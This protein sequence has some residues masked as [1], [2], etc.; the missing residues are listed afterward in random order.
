[1]SWKIKHKFKHNPTL[2]PSDRNMFFQYK[3]YILEKIF[4][5][6]KN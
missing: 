2:T 3:F 1:M 4:I 5:L 6:S